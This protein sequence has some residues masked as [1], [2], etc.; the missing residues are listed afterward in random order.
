MTGYLVART[1]WV[2]ASV[3]PDGQAL[4]HLVG[5]GEA[6]DAVLGVELD[7]RH[8][9]GRAGD[10]VG[11]GDREDQHAGRPRGQA[12]VLGAV[13]RLDADDQSSRNAGRAGRPIRPLRFET[14]ACV[15]SGEPEDLAAGRQGDGVRRR[16]E[17][18]GR[19]RRR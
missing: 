11:L 17:A 4:A 8:A 6:D 12:D 14:A 3:G 16:R 19:R 15:A 1:I 10:D 13:G 2:R 5:Q 7:R 9:L 18:D